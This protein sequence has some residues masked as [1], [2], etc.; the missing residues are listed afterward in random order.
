M[1]YW[2]ILTFVWGSIVLVAMYQNISFELAIPHYIAGLFW[3]IVPPTALFWM[4]RYFIWILRFARK[5]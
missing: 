2:T 1:I 4:G 5:R 3:I